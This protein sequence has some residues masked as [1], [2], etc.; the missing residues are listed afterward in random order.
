M[1]T[2]IGAVLGKTT[3]HGN[4]MGLKV[5]AEQLIAASAVEAFSAKLRVIGHDSVSDVEALDLGANGSN[6]TNGL[7]ARHKREFR[8]EFTLVD[9]QIGAANTT[10]L[11]LDQDIVGTKLWKWDVDN[12]KL[13]G[14]SVPTEGIRRQQ[15]SSS[16]CD[17]VGYRSSWSIA[18][19]HN[20]GHLHM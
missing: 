5:L 2:W 12:G 17:N 8:Q 19:R 14:L 6:L 13:F 1:F 16:C 3:V 18:T 10:S 15:G 7:M 9:V 11:D 4:T 20:W